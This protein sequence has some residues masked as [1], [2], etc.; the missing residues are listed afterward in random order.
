MLSPRDRNAERAMRNDFTMRTMIETL[1]RDIISAVF[2]VGFV[3]IAV[4]SIQFQEQVSPTLERVAASASHTLK[5][6][7]LALRETT[8]SL[9]LR[10]RAH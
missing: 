9:L 7:H 6:A 1:G 4:A 3:L 10:L 2:S 8:W 5:N